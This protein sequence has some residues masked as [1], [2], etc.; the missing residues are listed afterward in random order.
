MR[1]ATL[2]TL[3]RCLDALSV[4]AVALAFGA[5]VRYA[6]AD[7]EPTCGNPTHHGQHTHEHETTTP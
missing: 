7:Y 3:H 6:L 4:L 2:L 1:P 5:V